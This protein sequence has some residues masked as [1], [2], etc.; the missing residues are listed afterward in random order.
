LRGSVREAF[1]KRES[2]SDF[3]AEQHERD[4]P[5]RFQPSDLNEIGRRGLG[6]A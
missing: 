2:P 4:W 5:N 3:P 1:V 6:L